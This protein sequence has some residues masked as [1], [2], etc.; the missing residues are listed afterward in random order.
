M[1]SILPVSE[2]CN[3]V[4]SIKRLSNTDHNLYLFEFQAWRKGTV[5]FSTMYWIRKISIQ[6]CKDV[7]FRLSSVAF[8]WSIQG[9]VGSTLQVIEPGLSCTVTELGTTTGCF[10]IRDS[11]HSIKSAD[12]PLCRPTKIVNVKDSDVHEC[13]TSGW[14]LPIVLGKIKILTSRKLWSVSHQLISSYSNPVST[15]CQMK[16]SSWY[17]V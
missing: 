10:P 6:G 2:I 15:E 9:A 14:L 7:I 4:G 8:D 5:S 1:R 13:L 17:T 3:V 11:L 12:L 16:V